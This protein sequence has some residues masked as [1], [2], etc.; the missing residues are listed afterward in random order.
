LRKKHYSLFQTEFRILEAS[1]T[2][3]YSGRLS[4]ATV[5]AR[6]P[7]FIE[8]EIDGEVVAL[9]IEQ[10]TCYGLNRVGSRIWNL[11]ATPTRISDLCETL[12]AAYE[13]DADEC[14]RQVL[15]LLEELRT[16]G[17]ITPLEDK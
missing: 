14:E 8:A 1:Q 4:I 16:E 12:L 11:L 17:M 7:G 9:S 3:H 6:N 5:V 15:D 2:L 13:V 10:G